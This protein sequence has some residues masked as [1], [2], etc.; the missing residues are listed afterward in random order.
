HQYAT[1][2]VHVFVNGVQVLK[3][4]DHTGAKPGRVVRGPGWQKQPF[5][6]SYPPALH[7]LLTLGG[8]YEGTYMEF[9]L[10]RQYVPDLIR[11]ATDLRLLYY[12]E[13]RPQSWAPAHAWRRLAQL[14]AAEA[15][16]P[17]ST[18]F[19]HMVEKVAKELP[20]VYGMFGTPAVPFLAEYLAD[21]SQYVVARALAARTLEG[22]AA[23]TD[24]P[25]I[26]NLCETIL[27][28][29]LEKH[30]NNPAVLNSVLVNILLGMGTGTADL[31]VIEAYRAK[32]VMP[33]LS[34]EWKDVRQR[35]Q[36]P[37]DLELD[38]F[39]SEPDDVEPEDE[40]GP[41]IHKSGDRHKKSKRKQA[42]KT[43]KMN[44]KKKR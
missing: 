42:D 32:H 25:E 1:G 5:Q 16:E 13:D 29:Q 18:L 39:S 31:V 38:D 17:L 2:M 6:T 41:V 12:W 10:P 21:E 33:E 35:L 8:D 15:I 23:N 20:I 24:T 4:G 26:F 3:D 30:A 14:Q 28:D 22:V 40:I 36:L 37:E 11:M 34:G 44:R 9:D 19:N 43:K 27:I 7:P